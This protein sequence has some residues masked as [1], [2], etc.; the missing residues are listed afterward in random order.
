MYQIR[1]IA[2]LSRAVCSVGVSLPGCRWH[3][4][5]APVCR[6]TGE[7]GSQDHVHDRTPNSVI[8]LYNITERLRSQHPERHTQRKYCITV[9]TRVVRKVCSGSISWRGGCWGTKSWCHSSRLRVILRGYVYVNA[10]P[11]V[12][13][14]FGHATRWISVISTMV[15]YDMT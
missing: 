11:P 10:I 6:N 5:G 14:W 4:A 15:L 13:G 3:E 2:T 9:W 8:R 7:L 1:T 12:T